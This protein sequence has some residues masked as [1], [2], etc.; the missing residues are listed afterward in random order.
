MRGSMTRDS[1]VSSSSR[2]L[3][4]SLWT[5]SMRRPLSR[6]T[7]A[8]RSG[9]TQIGFRRHRTNS[10][11]EMIRPLQSLRTPRTIVSTSGSSG[12]VWSCNLQTESDPSGVWNPDIQ[13][14]ERSDHSVQATGGRI[15]KSGVVADFG[16]S[17][18][19]GRTSR[20]AATSV[21]VNR[22]YRLAVP[23]ARRRRFALRRKSFPAERTYFHSRSRLHPSNPA[24][25]H[26]ELLWI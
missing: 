2:I 1:F 10:T 6:C 11:E 18:L 22:Q 5:F 14:R 8:F 16:R 23:L 3:L 7:M 25:G 24:T 19:P 12:I 17:C 21:H 9:D 13:D 26:A 15:L 20:L 4:A